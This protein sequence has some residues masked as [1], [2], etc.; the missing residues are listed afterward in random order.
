MSSRRRHSLCDQC[1]GMKNPGV[2]PHRF[3]AAPTQECCN[4][5]RIHHSGIL[6]LADPEEMECRGVTG[7]HKQEE[8]IN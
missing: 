2:V 3:I 8:V 1:W 5:G 7:I 6:I 4:C